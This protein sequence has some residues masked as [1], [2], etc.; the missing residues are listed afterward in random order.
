MVLRISTKAF[1]GGGGGAFFVV[2]RPFINKY[3]F[4]P[5]GLIT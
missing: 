2:V 3:T 1:L 5:I 4:Q